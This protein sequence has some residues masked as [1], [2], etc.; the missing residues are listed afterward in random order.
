M[1][2][3]FLNRLK[4]E[5]LSIE[6]QETISLIDSL[7]LFTPTTFKN[8]SLKNE[9]NQNNGSCK[10]FSFAK[11]HQLSKEETLYCFGKF[12]TEDVIQHPDKEDHQNIRNFI[13]TGWDGIQFESEALKLK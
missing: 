10:I 6:F 5:P 2:T 12:Y 13:K 9:A 1:L 7:Y 3:L 4:K 11:K 8:G